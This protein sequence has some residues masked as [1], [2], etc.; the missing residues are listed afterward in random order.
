MEVSQLKIGSGLN[1]EP[2]KELGN[3]PDDFSAAELV[4]HRSNDYSDDL[5][6]MEIVNHNLDLIGD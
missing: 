1:E 6:E 2:E 4:R 3:W 5:P